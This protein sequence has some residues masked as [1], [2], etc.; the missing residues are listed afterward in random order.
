[1]VKEISGKEKFARK[2]GQD[3]LNDIFSFICEDKL[4][5]DE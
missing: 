4:F 5:S 1:M 2:V 3:I